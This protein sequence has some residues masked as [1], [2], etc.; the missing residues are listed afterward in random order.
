MRLSAGGI[1]KPKGN[2]I[3]EGLWV[4]LCLC[5][6]LWVFLLSASVSARLLPLH[7]KFNAANTI[8]EGT[9]TI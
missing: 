6:S 4:G 8:A 7:I 9:R 5:R 2:G 3:N 1:K